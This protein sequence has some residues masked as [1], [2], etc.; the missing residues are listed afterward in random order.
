MENEPVRKN[1]ITRPLGKRILLGVASVLV[2]NLPVFTLKNSPITSA[3]ETELLRWRF[4]IM[5]SLSKPKHSNDIV[6]IYLKP[7]NEASAL[8]APETIFKSILSKV[9]SAH[10]AVI[11]INLSS[12]Q[13]RAEHLG[14]II[15][16]IPNVVACRQSDP[17]L[18]NSLI[19][20]PSASDQ[21]LEKAPTNSAE[22]YI[23]TNGMASQIP[24][25]TPALPTEEDK[26]FSEDIASRYRLATRQ[27]PLKLND[28]P[29]RFINY[30]NVYFDT[31]DGT[32]A[33]SSKYLQGSLKNKIVLI[34]NLSPR[35]VI[36]GDDIHIHK[37][38]GASEVLVDAFAIQSLIDGESILPASRRTFQNVLY[39]LVAIEFLMPIVGHLVRLS[40]F[41]VSIGWLLFASNV[42]LFQ[43]HIFIQLWPFLVGLIGSF[44]FGSVAYTVTDLQE[45]NRLLRN[46][47]VDLETR[48]AELEKAKMDL[49]NR[50]KEIATARE[51]GME[52]ERKR[53]ALDLHDDALKELFLASSTVETSMTNGLEPSIGKQVQAKIHE[54][55][56][57]IRRIMA[58][59]SPSTLTVCG[60][61]GAIEGLTCTLREET[62]IEVKFDGE[63]GSAL[64]SFDEKQALL[65]YRIVQEAFNNIQKH[66]KATKVAV[67][68]TVDDSLLKIV[69]A[70]N[71]VGFIQN[72]ARTDGYGLNNMKHRAELIGAR[73]SFGQ[74]EEFA[75]GAQ[76]VLTYQIARKSNGAL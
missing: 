30:E 43:E 13:I 42:T 50:G 61:A 20:L 65:I 39:T 8:A 74:S 38:E 44:I 41:V 59:L 24:N 6:I 72:T 12:E 29:E 4:E 18:A 15:K 67:S 25:S 9:A 66:A 62:D 27:S 16:D 17:V 57:K 71:G 69:I 52:E 3:L 48:N 73:L 32:K 14:D 26:N 21:K 34:G 19:I 37:V 28:E 54:A 33:L 2:C 35:Y 7:S 36:P 55:S 40:I 10:P 31:L 56:E 60:L 47:Q 45:R 1:I 64:D 46:T 5:H 70:D 23:E 58:N 68:I 63:V 53:V 11:G 49:V 75:R 22:L 51:L 76:V